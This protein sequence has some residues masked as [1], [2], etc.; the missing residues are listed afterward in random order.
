MDTSYIKRGD[1]VNVYWDGICCESNLEI[2]ELPNAYG[3]YW[4]CKRHNDKIVYINNF[5]KMVKL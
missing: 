5:C 4:V 2:L 1:K 3:D